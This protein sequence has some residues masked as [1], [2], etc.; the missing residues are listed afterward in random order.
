MIPRWKRWYTKLL[1]C[2]SRDGGEVGMP[3]SSRLK[4]GI[5]S[6]EPPPPGNASRY[7]TVLLNVPKNL[8]GMPSQLSGADERTK[9]TAALPKFESDALGALEIKPESG[10]GNV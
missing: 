4:P 10:A 2:G 6:V 1:L 3:H 9:S 8:T 7:V 5:R